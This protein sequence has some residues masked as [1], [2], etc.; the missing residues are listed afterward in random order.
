MELCTFFDMHKAGIGVVLR[1]HEIN[2]DWLMVASKMKN[3]VHDHETIEFLT[4][5]QGLQL[6]AHMGFSKIIL[7]SNCLLMVQE[8]QE[9]K[10]S[11]SAIENLVKE[12]RSMLQQFIDF[13]IQHV[14][15][16]GMRYGGSSTSQLCIECMVI[17]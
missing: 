3:E 12:T 17:I 2:G 14:H 13:Q 10:Q 16:M 11:Y 9:E 7:E 1:D 8:L 6:C 5:L 4:I 15:R